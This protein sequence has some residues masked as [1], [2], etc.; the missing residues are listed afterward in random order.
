MGILTQQAEGGGGGG[1]NRTVFK[2][3]AYWNPSIK[4]NSSGTATVKFKLP[5]NL[6]TWALAAVANTRDTQVGQA[7][8]EITVTKDL[9][10]R[11]ILPNILRIGDKVYLSALVQNFTDTAHPFQVQLSFDSGEVVQNTWEHVDLDSMSSAQLEWEIIPSKVNDQAKLQFIASSEDGSRLSD[12]IEVELP[13]RRFGFLEK[14]GESFIGSHDYALK[15]DSQIDPDQSNIKLSFSPSLFGTLPTTMD[16][17]LNYAFGC[18]E[19]TVS[20]LVPALLAKDNPDLFGDTLKDKNLDKIVEKSL[21]RLATMQ[22][23]DGGWTWWYTGKSD[24]FITAYVVENL[25]EAENLGYKVKAGVIDRG[26]KYLS[27][28]LATSTR[29]TLEDLDPDLLALEVISNYQGGDHNPKTNGLTRL[30]SLAKS[31]GD[32]YFW[33]AGPKERFGSIEATTGMALRAMIVAKA[34]REYIDKAVRYLT[35]SRQSDYWG[36]TF[37]TSQIITGL[38][39]YAKLSGDLAPAFSYQVLLGADKLA[40]GDIASSDTKI[41]DINIPVSKLKNGNNVV[42]VV[43]TGE[44]NLY[45]TLLVSQFLTSPTQPSINRG[46]S[47]TKRF[48]NVKGPDFEIGVGDTVNVYLTVSG[49]NSPDKYGVMTDELPSGMV[50]VNTSLKNEQSSWSFPEDYETGFAVTDTEVNENGVV[51]SL[52]NVP[53]EETTYNYKARVV[54]A[55]AYNIPPATVSLMYSPEIYSRSSTSQIELKRS[56][57]SSTGQLT[58]K[59]IITKR[60]W[61][62]IGAAAAGVIAVVLVIYLLK[63]KRRQNPADTPAPPDEL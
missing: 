4:T 9:I 56:P 21:E 10:V 40:S 6:T 19:Q 60:I 38:V 30:T 26:N 12:S 14:V 35:R 5:D 33:S 50:P 52:Y 15:L 22:R 3:T 27:N 41:K 18:V 43:Q 46:I 45:S 37:A 54:S 48:E 31:Q 29:P 55:G 51:M 57:G 20:R 42:R 61:I 25:N 7:T 58:N 62:M 53:G 44:G 2:D 63:K 1:E 8:K 13:V 59:F 36:N 47:I 28:H 32:A 11:P 24:P 39:E 16:Y 34:D 17:L 23:G 49:L